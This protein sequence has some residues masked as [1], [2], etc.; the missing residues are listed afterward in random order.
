[1]PGD[2]P[3]T[4]VIG[5]GPAGLIA[6]ERLSES[7]DVTVFDHKRSVGRKFLLAGRGGLNITHGEPIEQLLDRYDAA[8]AFLEPAIRA[9]SPSD[10]RDWSASLGE[11][12][13]VGTSDRIFPQS[14]R[15]T[16]L[17]RAWLHRLDEAGV[18]FAT[19]HR[20]LGWNDD[21]TVDFGSAKF[22]N[23]DATVFAL[24]GASW[25][26]VGSDGGWVEPFRAAGIKVN[27]LQPA[28]CGVAIDWS[29]ALTDKFEGQPIK[30]VVLSCRDATARGD[31]IVTSI[32][33]EGGPVYALGPAVRAELA[34]QGQAV[35]TVDTHPDLA[36]DALIDRLS[37]RRPRAS[38]T[39]WLGSA[40]V[41]PIA[42]SLAREATANQLPNEPHRLAGLLKALPIT[43]EHMAPI[44]RAISS[45]GGIALSEIDDKFMIARRPGVFVAGEMIDWEAP[46]GGYLLQA[47]FSTG[48]AA[49]EGV[50]TWLSGGQAQ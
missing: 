30:N 3:Y 22:A 38:L 19:D 33:L 32:G 13:F 1:M 44:D 43:V 39:S 40:G 41:S 34:D 10:L 28:N 15:A 50:L 7:A 36:L 47:C 21:G 42:T 14:F 20:W 49:A 8:R 9:F 16:P 23:F 17:L 12:T 24:G 48:V 18:Q 26:R 27:E 2:R 37:K 29:R 45:A 11:P 4:A 46:T 31:A 35:V 6:A 5:G 25:P